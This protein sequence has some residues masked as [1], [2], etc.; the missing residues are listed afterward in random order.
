MSDPRETIC[1]LCRLA[2]ANNWMPGTGGGIGICDGHTAY[3]SPSG[4]EKELTTKDQIVAY[5]MNNDTYECG[6]GGLRPSACTPLF[7]ELFR[8]QDMDIGCVIHTHSLNAVLCSMMYD[9][10]FSISNMEQIKA[11]P[12]GEGR[13]LRNVETLRIP[14]IENAPEEQDLMPEL[15]RIISE[16]PAACA[17]LVRRHGLFVW[18]ATAKKAKIY[19]ESIDYLMEAAVKMRGLAL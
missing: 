17:V 9:A 15:K 19:V 14:I 2:Y 3:I 1:S 6:A 18:G 5:D 12:S 11:L 4:I 8:R 16:Y 10:E 13:N 7:L